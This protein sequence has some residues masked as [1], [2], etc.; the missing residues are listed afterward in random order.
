M[1]GCRGQCCCKVM[2]EVEKKVPSTESSICS[3]PVRAAAHRVMECG[4]A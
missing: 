3:A 4:T 1:Q 2:F